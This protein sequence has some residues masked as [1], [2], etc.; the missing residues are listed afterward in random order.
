MVKIVV[1]NIHSKI[2]GFLSPEVHVDLDRALSYRLKNARHIPLVKSGKWDGVFHLYQKNKGQSFYTGLMA[3]VREVLNKHKVEFQIQDLRVKPTQNLPH[4]TFN[5]PEDWG[6]EERDYQTFSIDR[7]IKFTRGV[8]NITTG[9]GKTVCVTRI[10]SEIKTA[11]FIFYVLTKDLMEQAYRTMTACLNEPI[12]RIGDGLCDIK[13]INVCT[14]QT[15]IMALKGKDKIK[16]S[17]Y[18]FDEEDV[19][20]EKKI[21]SQEKLDQ[22]K[23]L[24]A[25]AKGVYVDE[26]HHAAAK[27]V[28]EVLEASSNAY[29]R[30]GGSATPYR[31]S[32]D[33]IMIQ[34]MF[35][36]KIVDISASYLIKKGVL[37][38][39][40]IFMVPVDSKTNYHSY[41][42]IYKECIVENKELNDSIAETAN[43]LAKRRLSCLVLVQQYPQGDYLKDKINDV[44]F[45]TGKLTTKNRTRFIDDLREGKATTMIATS[46]ADE[47]LDVP[48]LDSALLAG[49]GASSTRVNQ[50]I[51]RTLRKDREGRKNKSIVVIYCHNAKH[52]EKHAKKVR[53]ILRREPEFQIIESKGLQ[54]ICEEIDEL[55]GV[56]TEPTNLF[57]V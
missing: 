57:D 33:E 10:I 23:K 3:F 43:H 31:E 17:D 32:G 22:I 29:W 11:P 18:K 28:K 21:D 8:L 47:G 50:R 52:L 35:G 37:V 46:L 5:P 7:S 41:P 54:Y 44:E 1:N 9:G 12:G 36:A 49:G 42:K 55:L 53:R 40:Y 6:Y 45:V 14:I 39:P 20:D 56:N 13:N 15:A 26:C 2:V 34:A 48:T 24:I 27:T 4:L 19:W 16:I 30:F 51:G 25:Q 38:K